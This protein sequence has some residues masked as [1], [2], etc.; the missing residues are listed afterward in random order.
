M[1]ESMHEAI[2]AW[3]EATRDEDR[4]GSPRSVG[5]GG[6]VS[7]DDVTADN[8]RSICRLRLA[9]AQRR[10][11]APNAVSLA[12]AL[13]EP[14]A[15]YRAIT[16]DDVIVGFVMLYLDEAAANYYLWR[17]MIGEGYQA[18]GF[19]RAAVGLVIE[20]VRR[21]PNATDLTVGY[22]PGAEGPEAFYASLGFQPT[23]EIDGIDI[24]A[25]LR[26]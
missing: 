8:V 12:E 11:V 26:V 19:G 14:K 17:L 1:N 5:G 20:H 18:R 2:T 21:L 3:A 4:P 24:V 23:G 16:A 7:L 22:V 15:W 25:R 10:F 13:F 6:H 9:P